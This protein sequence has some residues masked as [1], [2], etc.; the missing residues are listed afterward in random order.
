MNTAMGL[1]TL[2]PTSICDSLF[3]IKRNTQQ[4]P[5]LLKVLTTMHNTVCNSC[6]SLL[7]NCR[8]PNSDA[9]LNQ[10][11]A[12]G[13]SNVEHLFQHGNLITDMALL[14]TT[15]YKDQK[16]IVLAIFPRCFP[17]PFGSPLDHH[18]MSNPDTLQSCTK[19]HAHIET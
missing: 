15:P 3:Q 17:F 13:E 5:F 7:N 18:Q 4:G 2:A 16:T 14:A 6:D 8:Q 12:L 19:A 10:F 11:L 9:V 1:S